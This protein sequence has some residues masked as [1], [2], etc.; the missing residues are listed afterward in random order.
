MN[1]TA[2]REFNWR[3]D[4]LE[5]TF[6]PKI[7][8]FP[9]GENPQKGRVIQKAKCIRCEE[10]E[11]ET[12]ILFRCPFSSQVWQ[13]MD[14][15]PVVHITSL[16]DFSSALVKFGKIFCVPPRKCNSRKNSIQRSQPHPEARITTTT[17]KTDAAWDKTS[18]QAGLAWILSSLKY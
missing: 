2:V 10:A 9:T 1:T 3:K 8:V 16:P 7:N 13:R 17:C 12:R 15:F 5:G 18:E 4:V 6:S 11:S 14:F